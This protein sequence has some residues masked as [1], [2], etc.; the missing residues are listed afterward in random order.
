LWIVG[1]PRSGTTFL[2]A[3]L[4]AHPQV[5]LTVEGRL[6]ALLKQFVEVDCAR[7][8]LIDATHRERFTRFFK[9][10]AGVLIE[11]YYREA[12]GIDT[13]IWGDKHPPYGDPALL[14]GRDGPWLREPASGSALRLIDEVLPN[15]KFIHIHR[16][17][18]QVAQSLLSRG[19]VSSLGEGMAVRRQYVD[20]IEGFFAG[21]DG[22]RRLTLAYAN[23]LERPDDAAGCVARFLGI[24]VAPLTAFLR[25]ERRHPTPFSE[26]VR[27]LTDVYR[28]L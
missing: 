5:T 13:A 25:A 17:T 12:L 15:S 18:E 16:Q 6:F 10:N 4:N 19:W 3:L 22:G 26:P 11:R 9:R 1:A 23:L 20:E 24:A 7:P 28:T 27:N 14:S 21:I 8:D 2:A